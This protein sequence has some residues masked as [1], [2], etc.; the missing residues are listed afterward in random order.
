M[1]LKK[2]LKKLR[3]F[4][5]NLQSEGDTMTTIQFTIQ[6]LMVFLAYVIGIVAGVFLIIIFWKIRKV[7]SNVQSLI[8]TNQEAITKTIK[9]I[10]VI[11]DDVKLIS[12]NVIVISDSLKVSVPIILKGMESITNTA[13]TSIEVASSVID[14]VGNEINETVDGYKKDATGI[15]AYIHIAEEIFNIIYKAFTS[16]K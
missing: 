12:T 11:M 7:I 16:K 5:K 2:K 4:L 6:D 3:M 9:T 1:M 13:K 8:D 14:N 10:P 15:M